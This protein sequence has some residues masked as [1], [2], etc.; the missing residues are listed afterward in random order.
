MLVTNVQPDKQH[1]VCELHQ[2]TLGKATGGS[3][4]VGPPKLAAQRIQFVAAECRQAQIMKGT[5][6]Q[7]LG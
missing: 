7:I 6:A 2:L 4:Q 3:V 1:L 5:K